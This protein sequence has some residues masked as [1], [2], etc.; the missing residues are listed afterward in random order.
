MVFL[1]VEEVS[2]QL[3]EVGGEEDVGAEGGEDGVEDWG[4]GGVEFW[5][6][7]VFVM[8]GGGGEG[9]GLGLGVEVEAEETGAAIMG[10]EE[11]EGSHCWL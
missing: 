4:G 2:L 10:R 8:G 5:E 3:Y 11:G 1:F 7:A 6:S 9:A